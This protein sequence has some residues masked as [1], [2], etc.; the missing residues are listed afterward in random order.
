MFP[1]KRIGSGRAWVLALA[2][3][4]VA[5]PAVA[6]AA[7]RHARMAD[8]PASGQGLWARLLAW[9]EGGI[10]F[11]WGQ[12]SAGID[13]LGGNHATSGITSSSDSGPG[14]DPLGG[15]HATTPGITSNTDTSS[16]IDPLGGPR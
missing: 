10:S 9:V 3:L 16:Q 11:A 1:V 15:N 12:D 4:L 5:I 13:P 7:P 8:G 6:G 2:L 14:I